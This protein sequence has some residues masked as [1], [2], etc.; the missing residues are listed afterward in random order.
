MIVMEE[1]WFLV[2]VQSS[3]MTGMVTCRNAGL[4]R[5]DDRWGGR[6]RRG[7]YV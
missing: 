3:A 6:R 4:L 7:M 5:K 1:I 2:Q